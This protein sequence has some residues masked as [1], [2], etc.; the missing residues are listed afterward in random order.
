MIYSQCYIHVYVQAMQSSR[1]EFLSY[2]CRSF[3]SSARNK[4]AT[5]IASYPCQP[6][7][8]TTQC[9]ADVLMQDILSNF[10]TILVL[11]C[12]LQ[13]SI[14][15][16]S[17]P[18]ARWTDEKHM[19][20]PYIFY[21]LAGKR[22]GVT[23]RAWSLTLA[24]TAVYFKMCRFQQSESFL[25]IKL[26]PMRKTFPTYVVEFSSLTLP[27]SIFAVSLAFSQWACT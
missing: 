13:Q 23:T 24:L 27:S 6:P 4:C 14:P 3:F 18:L 10:P 26:V 11:S 17:L 9:A 1:V 20:W 7:T 25:R 15:C 19:K 5:S 16:D 21:H 12:I 2:T 8:D 22:E